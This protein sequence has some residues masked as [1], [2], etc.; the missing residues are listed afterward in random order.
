MMMAFFTFT[1]LVTTSYSRYFLT[2]L[3]RRLTSFCMPDN[4]VKSNGEDW[5]MESEMFSF[6]V[7][8]ISFVKSKG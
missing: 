6:S 7:Q 2:I 1:F 5:T 4:N 8:Y 3:L